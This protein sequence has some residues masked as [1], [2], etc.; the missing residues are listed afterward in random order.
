M[1]TRKRRSQI[2]LRREEGGGWS[3]PMRERKFKEGAGSNFLKLE[4]VLHPKS[5]GTGIKRSRDHQGDKSLGD[6]VAPEHCR[7]VFILEIGRQDAIVVFGESV[8]R[9]DLAKKMRAANLDSRGRKDPAGSR[10][11]SAA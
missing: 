2:V 11:E 3:L 6:R 9:V 1:A 4:G 7:P 8:N 5:S 10:E